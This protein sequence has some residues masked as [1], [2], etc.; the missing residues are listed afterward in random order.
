MRGG[1]SVPG[2]VVECVSWCARIQAY[3]E[4]WEG[5]AGTA[6]VGQAEADYGDAAADGRV[7]DYLP[8]WISREQMS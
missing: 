7:S 6:C 2:I 5:G 4:E 8:E 3:Y 1:E